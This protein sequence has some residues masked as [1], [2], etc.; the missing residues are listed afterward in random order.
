MINCTFIIKVKYNINIMARD[1]SVSGG[2]K[3]GSLNKVTIDAKNRAES[4]MQMIESQLTIEDIQA[5]SVG[6][7]LDL[8]ANL[9]EYVA[10]KLSRVDNRISGNIH[11]SDEPINFE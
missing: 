7:R 10:P 11:L 6:K 5:L 1:G 3:K 4:L 8:Y 9:L 2:R